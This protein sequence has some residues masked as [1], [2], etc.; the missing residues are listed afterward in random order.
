MAKIKINSRFGITPNEL[1]NNNDVTLKAKGLYAYIQSKSDDWDFSAE[2]IASQSKESVDAIKTGL[3]ELESAGYLKRVKV[4][5]EKGYFETE[6]ILYEKPMQ[7]IPVQEKPTVDFPTLDNGTNNSNKDLSKKDIKNKDTEEEKEKPTADDDND[8]VPFFVK[9][10]REKITPPRGAGEIS[11]ES[12]KADF[13]ENDYCR[14]QA[15]REGIQSN[16]YENLVNEFILE[17]FG[18][19]ENTK[20]KD[21]KDARSHFV[22]WIPYFKS[23]TQKQNEGSAK[24]TGYSN[25]LRNIDNKNPR[26][27]F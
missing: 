20:W 22:R 9:E 14:M 12:L 15:G 16:D 19:E 10:Q 4:H 27:A 8:D 13:S 6:Y 17:K 1:L 18:L 11:R 3:R 26:A 24:N 2:K 5:N 25:S 23:K 21:I 7:D